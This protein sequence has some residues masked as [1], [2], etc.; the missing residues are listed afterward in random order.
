MKRLKI[1]LGSVGQDEGVTNKYK[2]DLEL[3]KKIFAFF[4]DNPESPDSKVHEFAGTLGIDEHEFEGKIYK[5]LGSFLGYGRSIEFKGTYDPEQLKAGMKIEM[6]HTNH[7]LVAEKITKD[8]LAEFKNYYIP[9]LLE[10]EKKAKAAL[11]FVVNKIKRG[12]NEKVEYKRDY[13]MKKLNIIAQYEERKRE[14]VIGSLIVE[15]IRL[16]HNIYGSIF[17][18]NGKYLVQNFT[19]RP[20]RNVRVLKELAVKLDENFDFSNPSKIKEE[21]GRKMLEFIR[22]NS[23]ELYQE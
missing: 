21:E 9:Y 7:P 20:I 10:M 17:T 3:D 8:H 5:I 15:V 16:G 18:K 22:K 12:K 13:I 11:A 1:V 19:N 4:R 14:Y 23:K 2:G 6:E